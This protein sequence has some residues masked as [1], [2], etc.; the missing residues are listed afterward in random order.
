MQNFFNGMRSETVPL[1]EQLRVLADCGINLSHTVAPEALFHS[2]SREEFEDDPYVAAL[3]E[4][5]S[6][7]RF[8]YIDLGGG[9]DCLI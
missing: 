4:S 5:R 3:L 2:C 7:K 9:Q 6:D 8:T 1:D